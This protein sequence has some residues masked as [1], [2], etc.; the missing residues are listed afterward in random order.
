M[1]DR[2]DAL[3]AALG[4]VLIAVAGSWKVAVLVVVLLALSAYLRHR[5]V[6][7]S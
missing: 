1:F 4:V 6:R 3:L 7:H 2:E 5:Y